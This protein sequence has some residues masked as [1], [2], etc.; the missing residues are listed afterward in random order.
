MIEALAEIF[1]DV[2]CYALGA[3]LLPVISCGKCYAAKVWTD[4]QHLSDYKW[5]GVRKDAT[6]RYEVSE[7]M[8]T[9]F[10][11]VMFI[12]IIGLCLLFIFKVIV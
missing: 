1:L 12:M 4:K 11:F 5:H 8:V 6:G 7:P 9:L 10:G 2:I 3:A